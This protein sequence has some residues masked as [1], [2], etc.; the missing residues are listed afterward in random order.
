MRH[1][2]YKREPLPEPFDVWK[3]SYS[4]KFRFS[5]QA[6]GEP[7]VF[8]QLLELSWC[9]IRLGVQDPKLGPVQCPEVHGRKWMQSRN[10]LLIFLQQFNYVI[11]EKPKSL[12][13][14]NNIFLLHQAD[15]SSI[16]VW[17]AFDN[18]HYKMFMWKRLE[19][20]VMRFQK[21]VVDLGTLCKIP[22]SVFLI[23][24]QLL[25]LRCCATCSS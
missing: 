23:L 5:L 22:S 24:F 19:W 2:A 16:S 25:S 1:T 6:Q 10:M 11:L 14:E 8:Q 3:A 20:T 9:N 4:R 18:E 15:V 17:H 13:L 7:W 21:S 12:K